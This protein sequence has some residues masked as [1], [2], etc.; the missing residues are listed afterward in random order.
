MEVLSTNSALFSKHVVLPYELEPVSAL[1][2]L[3]GEFIVEVLQVC[4]EELG[5][6]MHRYTEYQLLDYSH[7]YI[8][9]GLV[10][11]NVC[12]NAPT[13]TLH[14]TSPHRRDENPTDAWEGYHF[15]TMTA[16]AGGVT[17]VVE[18]PTML[19]ADMN[20]S[21]CIAAK[22]AL[23]ETTSLYC[24]LGL[25]ALVTPEHIEEIQAMSE[26]GVLGFKSFVISPGSNQSYFSLAML[27]EVMRRV[28]ELY[29][30]FIVHP[31]DTTEQKIYK[32][33]PFRNSLMTDRLTETLPEYSNCFSSA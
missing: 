6:V 25:L 23:L 14:S 15:G 32:L 10:D 8:S 16:A 12:F 30:P 20:S 11:I 24:D 1:I 26:A 3:R 22:R 27:S 4:S 29:K 28:S 19:E 5:Q 9:P 33:S 17:T 7:L 21:E 2:L 13:A 31:T 18:S